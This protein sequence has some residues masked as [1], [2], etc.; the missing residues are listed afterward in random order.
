MAF[1]TLNTSTMARALK[2]IAFLAL[3][4]LLNSC[5]YQWRSIDSEESF[6]RRYPELQGNIFNLRASVENIPVKEMARY[7]RFEIRGPLV[8]EFFKKHK[9]VR[10]D[11]V[12]K[13]FTETRCN[14]EFIVFKGQSRRYLTWW[15]IQ[16]P[17]EKSCYIRLPDNELKQYRAIYDNNKEIMYL[18]QF[19]AW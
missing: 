18:Y 10:L 14:K 4:F 9:Y 12:S 7:S 2:Y 16:D 15:D 17:P 8:E 3:L 1:Y 13:Q 19:T 5:S 6:Y 11:L